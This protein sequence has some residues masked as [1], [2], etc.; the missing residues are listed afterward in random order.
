MGTGAVA[1]NIAPRSAV[2]CDS[3]PHLV[4]FY[5]SMANGDITPEVVKDYLVREGEKLLSK[6]EGHYYFI[7]ERFNSH[8]APL[9]FLFL[10][11]AGFNGMIRFNKKGEF[12]IPFCRKPQRFA[13]AYVTKIV[14]QVDFVSR[15]L[16]AKEFKFK[17]QDF[18]KTISEASSQDIIYCDPPYID[19]HVDYF[20]GWG[21][22]HEK[23]LYEKLSGFG[24]R[25]VLSTWHHND[26]RANEY[27]QSLWSNFNIITHEH[28]YHVGG[29]EVNRNPV[30]EAL[31][32]NFNAIDNMAHREKPVQYR[33]FETREKYSQR[34][35]DEASGAIRGNGAT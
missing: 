26:Y 10:N 29:K 23:Q 33:L 34:S 27:I 7:R 32:V 20:N 1:F 31:V 11:R 35:L 2:L 4:H 21:D 9:D 3:N 5:S 17:C 18:S 19:R 8:H 13:Q 24:G 12:N 28:F 6:G 22:S 30:I 25:F 15:L 14:N 16:K